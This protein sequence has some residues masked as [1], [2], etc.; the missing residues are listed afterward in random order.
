MLP[1][2][3][4]SGM[5]PAG[6]HL[7]TWHEFDTRFG[8]NQPRKVLI[9]HLRNVLDT[10]RA[11]G[12]PQAFVDGSFVTNKLFPGD[13]DLCWD[14][15]GVDIDMLKVIDHTLLPI[16]D[17]LRA[18]QKGR[19]RGDIFPAHAIERGS[20]LAFVMFFQ[21]DKVTGGRKGIVRLDLR[22]LP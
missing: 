20:G 4:E 15:T 9:G 21:R 13:Y 14:G 10:L 11:V 22:R 18:E 19:H 16:N 8:Y 12:S 5:L 17:V 3:T 7:A 6:I 1:S 2:F